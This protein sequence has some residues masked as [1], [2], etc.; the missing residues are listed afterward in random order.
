M[1]DGSGDIPGDDDV[2]PASA[3]EREERDDYFIHE[4]YLS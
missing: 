4:K 3:T 1:S 2:L